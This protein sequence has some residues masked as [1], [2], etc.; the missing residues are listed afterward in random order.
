[1]ICPGRNSDFQA[2]PLKLSRC[3]RSANPDPPNPAAR[4]FLPPAN[5]SARAPGRQE[6][7]SQ[8][9]INPEG[10]GK[11]SVFLESSTQGSPSQQPTQIWARSARMR[12][13]VSRLPRPICGFPDVPQTPEVPEL[14]YDPWVGFVGFGV[15]D[16]DPKS[17]QVPFFFFRA[18][19]Q[20]SIFKI[21]F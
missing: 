3:S 7:T 13:S 10:F 4:I 2:N 16:G 8:R 17:I 9:K 6:R 1:M 20:P 19:F 14:F 15:S 18:S 5:R 12:R 21:L 11:T